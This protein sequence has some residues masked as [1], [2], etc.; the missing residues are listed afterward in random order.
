MGGGWECRFWEH[1]DKR[2]LVVTPLKYQF[3]KLDFCKVPKLVLV[4]FLG[5]FHSTV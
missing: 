4:F 3:P 1:R 5:T 2:A